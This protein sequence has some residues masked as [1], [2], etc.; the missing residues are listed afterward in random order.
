V[1]CQEKPDGEILESL[2]TAFWIAFGDSGAKEA[3][4]WV[5]G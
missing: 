2:V 1:D 3:L 4:D 5:S